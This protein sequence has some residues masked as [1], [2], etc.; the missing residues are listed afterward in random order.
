MSK[1]AEVSEDNVIEVTEADLR[2][3]QKEEL[4]RQTAYYRKTCLQSFSRTRSG[5]TIKKAPFPTPRQITI[6]EDSD[7]MSKIVQQSVYQA[8]IDQSPVLS[9]TVYNVVISSLA[10]GVS[11]GYQGP[12][13]APPIT[14]LSKNI[15]YSASQPIQ[16]L[17][18]GSGA[19][20]SSIPMGFNGTQHLQPCPIQLSSAQFP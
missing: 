12:A 10:S 16:F 5:E 18:G 15:P 6:T 14:A 17:V 8:F 13:Y 9:N 20:S 11:H 3:D 4:E 2:D 7:K 19:S 1:A